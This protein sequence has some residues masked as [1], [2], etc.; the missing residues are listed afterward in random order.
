MYNF[1]LSSKPAPMK[2]EPKLDWFESVYLYE[3]LDIIKP[4]LSHE[5]QA[6]YSDFVKEVNKWRVYMDGEYV[7]NAISPFELEFD[8]FNEYVAGRVKARVKAM[9]IAYLAELLY[10]RAIHLT[11][12]ELDDEQIQM[13]IDESGW[14]DEITLEDIHREFSSMRSLERGC[15]PGVHDAHRRRLERVFGVVYP[16]LGEEAAAS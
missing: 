9:R 6:A 11:R 7:A 10:D 16:A 13:E 8:D 4:D 14:A 3:H 1:A 15:G 2:K 12:R 5:F